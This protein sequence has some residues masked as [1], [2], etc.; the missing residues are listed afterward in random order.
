M[1]PASGGWHF[2]HL[3]SPSHVSSSQVGGYLEE[4]EDFTFATVRKAGHEAPYTGK[5]C[6]AGAQLCSLLSPPRAVLLAF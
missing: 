6:T 1:P 2:R 3:T 5:P 4:Y